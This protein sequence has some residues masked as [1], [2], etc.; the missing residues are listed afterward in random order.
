MITGRMLLGT[1]ERPACA[2]IDRQRANPSG[3]RRLR[4]AS[5]A[6]SSGSRPSTAISSDLVAAVAMRPIGAAVHQ[7]K[8]TV[9]LPL[10]G[11]MCVGSV[12]MAFLGAQLLHVVGHTTP[13]EKNIE[14]ALGA[15]LLIGAAATLLRFALDR[16]NGHTRQGV[17][18]HVSVSPS[19]RRRSG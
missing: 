8:G 15:A 1:G 9:N 12:P 10:V 5:V 19:R 4:P 14:I 6:C 17:V 2:A 13:A 18:H 16:H 7:R 3:L 11:Y